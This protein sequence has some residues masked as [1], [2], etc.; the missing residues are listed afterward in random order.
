MFYATMMMNKPETPTKNGDDV[1]VLLKGETNFKVGW[2][3]TIGDKNIFAFSDGTYE[4]H[5]KV[6]MWC[7][8]P[9]RKT[10]HKINSL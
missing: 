9:T 2:H 4:F 6:D 8:M 3:E 10:I 7:E 5:D 1:L